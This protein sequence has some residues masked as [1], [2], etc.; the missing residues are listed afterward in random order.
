MTKG[1]C[2]HTVCLIGVELSTDGVFFVSE[3]RLDRLGCYR[4]DSASIHWNAPFN[5]YESYFLVLAV[6][7]GN[8]DVSI[9]PGLLFIG[10]E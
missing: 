5:R 9:S 3:S 2:L 8:I 6:T 10:F 7:V 4:W 1:I